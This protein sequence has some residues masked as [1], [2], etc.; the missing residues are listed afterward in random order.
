M[1]GYHNQPEMTAEVIDSDGWL[2]TG[3]IAEIK[4]GGHIYITGRIKN[5]IVLSGGKKFS[6]KK[7]KLYWKKA[8]CLQKSACWVSPEHLE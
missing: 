7:L 6:L 5:M 1:R 8:R 3:D 2:H 4:N